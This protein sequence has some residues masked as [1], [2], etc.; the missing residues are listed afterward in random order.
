MSEQIKRNFDSL[1]ILSCCPKKMRNSIIRSAPKDLI[2]SIC[3]CILNLLN[4][5]VVLKDIDKQKLDK[6]KSSLRKLLK[7]IS[8]KEKKKVLIQKGGFLQILLPS[9]ITGL[10]SIISSVISKE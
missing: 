1:K 4:G 2:D 5:N 7:R 9:I 10:A 6:H 3:E 8:L